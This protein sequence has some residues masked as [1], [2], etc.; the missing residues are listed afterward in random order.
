MSEVFLVSEGSYSDYRIIAVYDTKEAAEEFASLGEDREIATWELNMPQGQVGRSG[1][2]MMAYP[3]KEDKWGRTSLEW[4]IVDR[5]HAWWDATVKAVTIDIDN[6]YREIRVLGDD[7]EHARKLIQ[8]AIAEV[9][10][11][12]EGLT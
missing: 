6:G 10:A 4:K 1:Y 9:R 12:D 7:K 11:R 3:S 8:D 5:G 2:E